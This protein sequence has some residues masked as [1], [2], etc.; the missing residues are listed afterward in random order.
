MFTGSGRPNKFENP[1]Q[2]KVIGSGIFTFWV[3]PEP[4]RTNPNTF[5]SGIGLIVTNPLTRDPTCTQK[6]ILYFIIIFKHNRNF[7]S[8]QSGKLGHNII[9]DSQYYSHPSPFH[10]LFS[11]FLDCI[12]LP[13][14]SISLDGISLPLS[15]HLL[16]L[17][18]SFMFLLLHWWWIFV[19]AVHVP[20]FGEHR[21]SLPPRLPL[22]TRPRSSPPCETR[23]SPSPIAVLQRQPQTTV[24]ASF[25]VIFRPTHETASPL[26][27]SVV[28]WWIQGFLLAAACSLNFSVLHTPEASLYV[29][30]T[31]FF[32]FIL[33]WW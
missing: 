29:L 23:L 32:L 15:S 18:L 8:Y 27:V 22:P 31:S 28:E 21:A 26:L 6:I 1:T 3:Q 4:N 20:I 12:S 9:T 13:L 33:K 2:P 24:A 14:S 7:T 11:I 5:G 17:S 25:S 19:V 10:P 16:H 30:V